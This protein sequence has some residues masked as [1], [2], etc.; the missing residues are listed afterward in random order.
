MAAGRSLH[1]KEGV[2]GSSPSE[3]FKA[4]ENPRKPVIFVVWAETTEHLPTQEVLSDRRAANL[5]DPLGQL[6]VEGISGACP[7][8]PAPGMGSGNHVPQRAAFIGNKAGR[9]QTPRASLERK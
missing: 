7:E 1:G 6:A 2:D 8:K 4:K 9:R 5:E 3:G